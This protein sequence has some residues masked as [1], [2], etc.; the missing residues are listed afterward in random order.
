MSNEILATMKNLSG[1]TI[2]KYEDRA[3]IIVNSKK[4]GIIK[5]LVRLKDLKELKKDN[6]KFGYTFRN[7]K[8]KFYVKMLNTNT[9]TDFSIMSIIFK[10]VGSNTPMIPVNLNPITF[11]I[12]SICDMREKINKE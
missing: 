3:E 11:D 7:G 2:N 12:R 1:N 9:S 5:C 6:Y 10:E 8:H 4:Y